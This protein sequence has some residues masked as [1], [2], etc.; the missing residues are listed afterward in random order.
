VLSARL[1]ALDAD[2]ERRRA[3]MARY[4][5][6]LPA[7]CVP[8]TEHPAAE[9][10]HHLAVVRVP[11]RAAATAALDAAGIGWG[12]HYPV[13]CHRQ[14]AFAEFAD[15]PLPVA[16][17]AA[18]EILSLPIYPQLGADQVDRVCEVLGAVFR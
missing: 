18:E 8:V 10:V 14:P 5:A 7:G 3:V 2:N 16:E 4:R 13:P 12:V 17:R 6:G 15:G 1:R 9:C 11:D